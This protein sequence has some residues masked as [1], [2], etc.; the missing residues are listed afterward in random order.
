MHLPAAEAAHALRRRGAPANLVQEAEVGLDVVALIERQPAAQL[1]RLSRGT[2]GELG[3]GVN[4]RARR[5]IPAAVV[6]LP[7]PDHPASAVLRAGGGVGGR[8]HLVGA[9]LLG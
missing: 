6:R 8:M 2:V 7:G 5:V 9:G 1:L 3:V 4:T